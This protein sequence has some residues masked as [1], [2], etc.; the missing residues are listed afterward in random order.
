MGP[1]AIQFIQAV[2]RKLLS[3]RGKGI[4]SI[5]DRMQAEAKA[6]EIAETFRLSGLTPNKWDE[7]IKSENDVVKYLNIIESSKKPKVKQSIQPKPLMQSSKPGDVIDFPPD[8]VTD[9]TKA[10]PQPP[11][12]EVINGIQTTRGMGD[13]FPK[14]IKGV[15]KEA[16]KR[17]KTITPSQFKKQIKL[18]YKD[19]IDPNSELGKSVRMEA[20]AEKR[21]KKLNMSDA[22]IDLR[23]SRPYDTDDQ[24]I[25]RIKKQNKESA[26]RLRNK[27]NKDL[28]DPEK[29]AAGGVAGLLGERPGYGEGN[30]VA[31]E[32]A[33][34][35]KFSERVI[36][37]MDEEGFE[38]GEAVK[39]AM[40]E[41]YASGG[42]A[43]LYQGGQAQI[44]PNLSDIGHGSDALMARNALLTPGSQATTSTGLNYL[45]GEDNDTTRV[46]YKH[47]DMVLPKP[48]PEGAMDEYMLKQVL[49]PAGIRTLD[50]RTREMFIEIYKKKIREK[51]KKADGGPA[52]QNFGMGKRAFLKWMASGAAGIAG[53]K[54]G[55]F[56]LLKG[57]GKKQVIKELTTVPINNIEG[58]PVWFKPLVNKV[59]KEGDDITKKFA[60]AD[61]QIV[62]TTKL[63]NSQTD[64]IVTQD[65]S[66]GNVS[67]DIG[68]GKHGFADG[69]HGQPVRLEYKA[70]EDIMSGPDMDDIHKVGVREP[71]IKVK[72]R[73]EMTF[74]Q[75]KHPDKAPEEFWVEEAEFTG[76]HPENV[77]FEDVTY[78]KFG[79]HGSNFDEVEKFATGKVKKT[80]TTESRVFGKKYLSEGDDMAD[81][82]RI[83]YGKGDIVTKGIPALIRALLKNKKKV[84][85]AVDDIYPTGDYK[86][87]AEMAA[88]ALV[89]NN[90]KEFKG[91]L[92]EDLDDMTRSEVYGAVLGPIQNNALMVSRMKKATKPTKTLE[93][94]EKTGT[95][96]ISNPGIA[97]EFTR[98]MKET[99]PK[100][101]KDIEE[102][103]IL[104]SFDPKGK[105]GHA[106]GGR[107]SL[108]GGGLAGM[109][110]E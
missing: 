19:K 76:G 36:K 45:L 57:G 110:G 69:L 17:L 70:A 93:G 85:Q 8:R 71:H 64:V 106:T 18:M 31:D 97:D 14:Q 3:K 79:Q 51:N 34:Q 40:K 59:I 91:L 109:L 29:F 58:M 38:F 101:Y 26:E 65:L 21:L 39:E 81:G 13:L 46:P 6:G 96:D 50:P 23:G 43:G 53:A 56:G 16:A 68:M 55:L 73:D 80:K 62:H 48:K 88:D 103:I 20:E 98:F 102:K 86:Y 107:V 28:E 104:E 54:S 33:Q 100:G 44:E 108:S 27:K 9:W 90:P 32:D 66:T 1:K 72:R 74:D 105:K 10:R 60:E 75:K 99:D 47:G 63:P 84:K 67:V 77:K 22:E 49:S 89:E 42:R 41:G 95:I 37:L 15:S 7:F 61:R 4:A 94:I 35:K 25:A 92:R 12:I 87:D 83:G 11:T 24:I 30:G 5:G 82:G 52:R 78:E 2:A